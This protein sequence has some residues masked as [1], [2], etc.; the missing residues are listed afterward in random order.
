MTQF[1][2]NIGAIP[3]DGT[4]DP[5]RTA[6]NE[7]NL[8]FNQVFAAGPV[9]SNV[10]IANNSILTT[11]TNGNLVLSTNGTGVIQANVSIVP[12]LANLR[13][14]GSAAQRWNTVYT[15]YVDVSG[16]ATF[17]QLTVTGNLTV[18]G[19]IIQI[20]NLVTDAKT[21]QLAN[22]S[23][24]ANAANGSGITVGANDDLATFLF[25]SATNTWDT[26]IGLAVSG[27]ITGTSVAVSD[28]IIYGNLSVING[29]FTGNVT[30]SNFVGNIFSDGYYYANGTPI[31]LVFQAQPGH[32]APQ[33]PTERLE[34]PVLLAPQV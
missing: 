6:F 24:T 32:R 27:P 10:R 22:T 34:Q 14:L 11:N 13:N 16:P 8:N 30:A 18:N 4:G 15:Q 7:T 28:A 20:G 5:L 21:I 31:Q 25:N 29:A 19:D 9:L 17:S 1:V 3:N 2:I 12:N 26:N 33:V 23:A